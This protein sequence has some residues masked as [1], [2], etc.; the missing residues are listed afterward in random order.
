MGL[1]CNRENY[2]N[3]AMF[4]SPNERLRSCKENIISHFGVI[5]SNSTKVFTV[6]LSLNLPHT[7]SKNYHKP[8]FC[9]GW[10][11]RSRCQLSF[12]LYFKPRTLK[13]T[14]QTFTHSSSLISTVSFY[15]FIAKLEIFWVEQ[16]SMSPD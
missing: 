8:H 3:D 7:T 14:D 9:L 15:T 4:T 10:L 16:I 1:L 11:I 5:N 6:F 13:L 12:F 2:I